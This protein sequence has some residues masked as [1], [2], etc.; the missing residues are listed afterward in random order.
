MFG[1]DN[2]F[3]I[4][5]GNP[6]YVF[7]RNSKSKGFSEDSKAYYYEHYEL[8]EYQINLY[9]LFFEKG[10]NLLTKMGT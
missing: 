4:V 10:T 1:I 6:P 8:S 2:G 3:D 9:P 7:A 5:I